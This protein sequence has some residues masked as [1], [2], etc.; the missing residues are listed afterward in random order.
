MKYVDVVWNKGITYVKGKAYNGA[1]LRCKMEQYNHQEG[2]ITL[3]CLEQN[4]DPRLRIDKRNTGQ[5]S[6]NLKANICY[7][8]V[9]EYLRKALQNK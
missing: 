6:A 1:V 3:Q 5:H 9:H 4:L 2:Y 8:Y 7:S